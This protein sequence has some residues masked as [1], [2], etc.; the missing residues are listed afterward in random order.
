MVPLRVDLDPVGPLVSDQPDQA[1]PVTRNFESARV[2]R[3]NCERRVGEFLDRPFKSVAVAVVVS[4]GGLPFDPSD[5]PLDLGPLG[6]GSLEVKPRD[7]RPRQARRAAVKLDVNAVR[8]RG[9]VFSEELVA[10]GQAD[11][12]LSGVDFQAVGGFVLS[13]EAE[14]V[15]SRRELL[16][17]SRLGLGGARKPDFYQRPLNVL[18]VRQFV[19]VDGDLGTLRAEPNGKPVP[20][21]LARQPLNSQR[22]LAGRFDAVQRFRPAKQDT[23]RLSSHLALESQVDPPLVPRRDFARVVEREVQASA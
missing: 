17:G 9:K 23:Q 18:A 11:L 2:S 14:V 5:H 12:V 7:V 15:D 13:G 1:K 19:A 6:S 16:E 21:F 8:R 22:C 4:R 3:L 10:L 20:A